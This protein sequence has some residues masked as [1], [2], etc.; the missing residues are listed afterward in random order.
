MTL[1]PSSKVRKSLNEMGLMEEI[2]MH[3]MASHGR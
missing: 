3:G 2:V 1:P